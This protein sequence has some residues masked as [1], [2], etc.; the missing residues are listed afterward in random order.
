MILLWTLLQV[1]RKPVMRTW[2]AFVRVCCG[3]LCFILAY[4]HQKKIL[5]QS[6]LG[7]VVISSLFYEI[8]HDLGLSNALNAAF[9]GIIFISMSQV[10]LGKEEDDDD[11]FFFSL[12]DQSLTNTDG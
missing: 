12:S 6:Q 7:L 2:S 3:I 5:F 8:S 11:L 1:W 4:F 9:V 10:W